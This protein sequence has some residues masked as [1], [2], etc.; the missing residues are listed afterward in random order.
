MSTIARHCH[1]FVNDVA[2]NGEFV[3][4]V[5]VGIVNDTYSSK[6]C[7]IDDSVGINRFGRCACD[8]TIDCCTGNCDHIVG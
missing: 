1:S 2:D 3:G 5:V 8:D 4:H 6:Q 7:N